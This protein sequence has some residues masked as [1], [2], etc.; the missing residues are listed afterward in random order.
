MAFLASEALLMDVD[1][2][3]ELVGSISRNP[4]HEEKVLSIMI[5]KSGNMQ[6][7]NSFVL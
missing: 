5:K 4:L 1:A 7:L 2:S 6:S 3:L